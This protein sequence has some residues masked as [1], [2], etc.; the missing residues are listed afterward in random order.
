MF[1]ILPLSL[2]FVI[3]I[4]IIPFIVK[5]ENEQEN[6][7]VII[8]PFTG[9]RYDIYQF[10]TP[11]GTSATDKKLSE[12]TW[13]NHISETGIKIQT[14]PEKNEFNL[15]GQIK[16]GYILNKSKDQDS[17]WDDIGEFARSFS[18]VKGNV[19]DISGAVG[20]SKDL[21][22][23]LLTYY[24]GMDYTKYD[25][26]GYGLYYSIRRIHNTDENDLLLGQTHPESELVTKYSFNNYAPWFGVSVRYPI[27]EKIIFIP[28]VKIYGF[29]LSSQANWILRNDL[30]HNPSF[31]NK[32]LGYGISF[33]GEFLYKYNNNLDFNANMG[34]KKLTMFQGRSKDFLANGESFSH[35]LKTLSFLSSSIS[36]GIKYNL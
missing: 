2:F 24:V 36:C 18:S 6:K 33:D 23:A 30:K 17:D 22:E 3:A 27:N 29:Y 31:T 12:L 14:V 11:V 15:L 32:A 10:S 13:K 25:T 8:A 1:R 4:L 9:Y 34:I 5:A 20:F 7:G 19:F 16:Y 28:T 26:K 21:T 35:D